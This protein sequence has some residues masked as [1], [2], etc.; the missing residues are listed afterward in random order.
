M[1]NVWELFLEQKQIHS[2]I[3]HCIA[4]SQFSCMFAGLD[5][6]TN[7]YLSL[8]VSASLQAA[9]LIRVGWLVGA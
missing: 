9:D 4:L 6:A 7:L 2:L 5:G 8:F 3:L 1:V